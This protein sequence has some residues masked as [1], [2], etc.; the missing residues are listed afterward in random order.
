[1]RFI[2][3]AAAT[4]AITLTLG[5]FNEASAWRTRTCRGK[6]KGIKNDNQD[7]QMSRA[8]IAIGG[9]READ[10]QNSET[11]WNQPPGIRNKIDVVG[12]GTLANRNGI[13]SGDG[14]WEVAVMRSN[15]MD[16]TRD[17]SWGLARLRYFPCKFL[18]IPIG[19]G[20]I[21][22]A[23]V[24]VASSLPGGEPNCESFTLTRREVILHEMGHAL[25]WWH[26]YDS[27]TIMTGTADTGV[28]I[29]GRYCNAG[30]GRTQPHPDELHGMY[31]HYAGAGTTDFDFAPTPFFA[32]L[33]GGRAFIRPTW[34]NM[35]ATFISVCPGASMSGSVT[36]ASRGNT[37]STGVQSE[38]V[39][40]TNRNITT[41]DPNVRSGSWFYNGLTGHG[42]PLW[43][44]N[45]TVPSLA[46]G[47]RNEGAIHDSGGGFAEFDETNNGTT[48][49]RQVNVLACP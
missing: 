22:E 20:E 37:A 14:V 47:I 27:L 28:S 5:H 19:G 49:G 48:L 33:I 1:M 39:L 11:M 21:K 3:L 8:S 18:G 41:F 36:M 38:I 23:D 46:P 31:R 13:R 10:F 2:A 42:V 15:R 25:G 40:S 6:I 17:G 16:G 44:Y 43:N 12:G 32:D 7:F 30:T 34:T 4:A 26:D 35:G 9:Q 24:W 45:Y 29:P